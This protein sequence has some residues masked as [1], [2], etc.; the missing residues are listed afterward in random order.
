MWPIIYTE[1]RVNVLKMRLRLQAPSE[2]VWS[3]PANLPSWLFLGDE[4]HHF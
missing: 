1:K 4:L 3:Q 2:G